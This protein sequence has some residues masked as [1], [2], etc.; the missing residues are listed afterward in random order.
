MQRRRRVKQTI[1]LEQRIAN[2]LAQQQDNLPPGV[3]REA[4]LEKLRQYDTAIRINRW[5][6]SAE[7]KSPK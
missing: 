5:L 3:Q 6:S 1:L 7:L 2:Y 4:Y